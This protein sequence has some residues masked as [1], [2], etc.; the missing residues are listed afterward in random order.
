MTETFVSE[1][2]KK[3]EQNRTEQQLLGL[4]IYL[5]FDDKD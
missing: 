2:K 5:L 4:D 3:T 1:Q